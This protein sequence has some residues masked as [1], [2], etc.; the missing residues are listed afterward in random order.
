MRVVAI[1]DGSG[2]FSEFRGD[3]GEIRDGPKDNS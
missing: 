3:Q 1:L 2:V